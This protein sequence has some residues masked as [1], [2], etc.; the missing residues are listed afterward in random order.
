MRMTIQ[1]PEEIFL[2]TR[3]T[4]A[5]IRVELAIRLFEKEYLSFGQARRISGLNVIAFQKTLADNEIPLHYG[6]EE[7]EK[8]LKK[9]LT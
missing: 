4:E 3:L 7:F 9:P 1:L 6:V 2:Q 5:E 8:D